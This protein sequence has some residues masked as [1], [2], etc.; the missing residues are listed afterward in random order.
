MRILLTGGAGY[1]GSHTCVELLMR[2]HDVVVIDN[3]SNSSQESLRRVQEITGRDVELHVGDLTSPSAAKE[4]FLAGQIDAVVHFAGLKAVGESVSNPLAYYQANLGST[5]VLLETMAEF[6]VKKFVFSSS[7]TVYG[8][9]DTLPSK[10]D[11]PSGLNLSNPY[12]RTKAMIEQILADA[13]QAD[14]SLQIVVLR[15]FNP[16]GAHISGRIGEDPR[17]VPNNLL[18]FVSQVAIGIRKSVAVFGNA[19]PTPDGTG[20]RDYIHVMDLAEG[21]A[22]ALE[23]LEPG[24]ETYNLGTGRGASVLEIIA[25]F[26]RVSGRE[27]PYEI[28]PARAGDIASSYADVTKA[29]RRLN[30]VASRS[31]DVAC[32]DAW[33]WQAANPTGF[34]QR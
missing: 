10:E 23:H 22:A 7:A 30:W 15:Y 33:A 3:L 14:P 16:I 2:G 6:G 5:L 1:I 27:I 20:V 8:D 29:A 24:I 4:P 32:R 13:S 18:P 11:S 21:H 25:A 31:L 19:Y 17:Q 9:P 12:G 28:V 34:A 26:T